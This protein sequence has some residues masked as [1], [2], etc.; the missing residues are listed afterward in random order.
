MAMSV[1][2]FNISPLNLYPNTVA[3]II[4]DMLY[5][6]PNQQQGRVHQSQSTSV[7]CKP[8][9]AAFLPST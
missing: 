1:V 4:L 7:D 3:Y 9:P 8:T 5:P 2:V 6:E